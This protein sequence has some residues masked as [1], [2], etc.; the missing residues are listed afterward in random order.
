LETVMRIAMRCALGLALIGLGYVIGSEGRTRSAAAQAPGAQVPGAQPGD[1]AA[2]PEAEST[3]EPLKEETAE[4]V[5]AASDA[6]RAAMRALEE[7]G[8]YVPAVNGLNSFAVTVGGV[9]AIRDLES[10]GAVDP[11]TFALLY[12]EQATDDVAQN[13]GRDKQGRLTYKN[14]VIRIYSVA[15]LRQLLTN[16]E[17]LATGT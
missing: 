3:S 1:P 17:L 2:Q 10:D 12:A 6:L 8:R 15:R 4:K 11:E 14:K 5:K 9:D 13:I 16:R 7:D